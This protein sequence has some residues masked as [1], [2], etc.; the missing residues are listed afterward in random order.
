MSTPESEPT[1]EELAYKAEA[2]GAVDHEAAE[3]MRQCADLESALSMFYTYVTD[4]D[5]DP[6][7]LLR[8]WGII[9]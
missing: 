1:V 8:E 5:G 4:E 3:A 7:A 2:A 6:E 9:I